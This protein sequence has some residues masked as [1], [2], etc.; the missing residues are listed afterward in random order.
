MKL[1][2]KGSTE[3]DLKVERLLGEGVKEEGAEVHCWLCLKEGRFVQVLNRG[4]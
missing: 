4:L 1:G 3:D 2:G